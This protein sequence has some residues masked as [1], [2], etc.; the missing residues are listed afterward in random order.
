M[1][2]RKITTTPYRA[3]AHRRNTPALNPRTGQ[4][5]GPDPAHIAAE[6]IREAKRIAHNTGRALADVIAYVKAGGTLPTRT[7]TWKIPTLGSSFPTPERITGRFV[8]RA[9]RHAYSGGFHP[10]NSRA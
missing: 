3:P 6:Q 7:G 4:P 5:I 1:P 8:S 9:Y 10:A 2:K